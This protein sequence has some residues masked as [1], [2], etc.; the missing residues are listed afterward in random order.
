MQQL[1]RLLYQIQKSKK[2]NRN[3]RFFLGKIRVKER[4]K[5]GTKEEN[6]R[7]EA[8]ISNS[9]NHYVFANNYDILYKMLDSVEKINVQKNARYMLI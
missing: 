4:I 6:N 3:I 1:Q 8:V 9:Y 5:E 7:I 2:S